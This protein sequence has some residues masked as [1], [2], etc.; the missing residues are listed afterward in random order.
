MRLGLTILLASSV[1]LS[2]AMAPAA[3]QSAEKFVVLYSLSLD[4]NDVLELSVYNPSDYPVCTSIDHWP[5]PGLGGDDLMVVGRD[6]KK[7]EY[8]G[9]EVETFGQPKDIKI[10]AQSEIA[11]TIDIRKN[12]K[13]V[14]SE[15][16]IGKVYYGTWFTD[17]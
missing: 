17:C 9:L 1:S 5:A 13:P 7:W 6:G 4:H 14:S 16:R 2:G 15:A 3:P 8:V 12:Y 11:I 10:P